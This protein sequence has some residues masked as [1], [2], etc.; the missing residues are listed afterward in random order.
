MQV[1][2]LAL[3]V[4]AE[5]WWLYLL[6]G[7]FVIAI[8]GAIPSTDAMI[9]RYV[10]DRMRSRVAGMRLAVSFGASS[11]AVWLS[12]PLV[13]QAGFS[14]LLWIMAGIAAMTFTIVTWL[15]PQSQNA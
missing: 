15:P 3:A 9:V 13:K 11:L 12:G 2:F 1:P 4:H 8:F 7:M 14:V 5:S 10:D 6:Q